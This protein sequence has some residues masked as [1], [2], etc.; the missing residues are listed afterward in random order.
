MTIARQA[1]KG[2]EKRPEPKLVDV[3]D[4]KVF[5]PADKSGKKHPNFVA[6]KGIYS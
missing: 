1:A 5:P 2:A 3:T 4:L 6:P